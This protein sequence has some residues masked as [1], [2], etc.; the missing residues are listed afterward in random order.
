[1]AKLSRRFF[2]TVGLYERLFI[3]DFLL[4]SNKKFEKNNARANFQ[5]DVTHSVFKNALECLTGVGNKCFVDGQVFRVGPIIKAKLTR[6]QY[7]ILST[8]RMIQEKDI[9]RCE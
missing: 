7:F 6:N 2:S 9:L 5:S 3:L 1:M 4:R 8:I